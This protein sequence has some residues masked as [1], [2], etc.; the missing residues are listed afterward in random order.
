[1]LT[2]LMNLTCLR[3]G[4]KAWYEWVPTKQ[5]LSDPLSRLG[6]SDPIVQANMRSS[7]WQSLGISTKVPWHLFTGDLRMALNELAALGVPD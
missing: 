7:L 1:V 6:W 2:L 4:I 5:N 3:L